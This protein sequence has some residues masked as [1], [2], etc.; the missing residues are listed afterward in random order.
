MEEYLGD[1]LVFETKLPLKCEVASEQSVVEGMPRAAARNE[2][3]LQCLI[4]LDEHRKEVSEEDD[5][6]VAELL[7]LEAKLDMLLELVS[8]LVQQK[9]DV[10]VPSG[11][12]LGAMGMSWS[13]GEADLQVGQHAWI[14][15][16]IDPRLP[17][18]LKLPVLI[19]EIADHEE[20][21]W[22]TASFLEQ[23]ERFTD[24]LQKVIFRHHRR[25]V[26]QLRAEQKRED[27]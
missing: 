13:G 10:E 23:G 24:L 12:R 14:S 2:R 17:Q 9:E 11:L 16:A 25:Q 6:R 15:L 27:D 1:G 5:D 21:R 22:I 18:S 3:L 8:G 7:R 20:G 4:A 19:K 26:A